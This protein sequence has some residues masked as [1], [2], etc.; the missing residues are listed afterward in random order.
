MK[1]KKVEKICSICYE[2][3]NRLCVKNPP[4]CIKCYGKRYSPPKQVCIKCGGLN[5]VHHYNNG[6]P[7]C[8]KCGCKEYVRKEECCQ[9]CLENKEIH[10]RQDGKPVCEACYSKNCRP[11]RTCVKC[12]N[13]GQTNGLSADGEGFV[14]KTC[15]KCPQILCSICGEIGQAHSSDDNDSPICKKCYKTPLEECFICGEE[16]HVHQRNDGNPICLNCYIPPSCECSV[17]HRLL[18]VH[19]R[20]DNLVL[21]VTC[22]KNIKLHNDEKFHTISLLRSRLYQAFISYSLKGKT[23][24]SKEYGIDYQAIFEYLGPCPGERKDWH[25]DHIIPLCRFDFDDLEQIKLAFASNNHQWLSAK[26]NMRKGS[27]LQGESECLF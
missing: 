18:P 6:N 14:C 15:Y 13:I 16:K 24:K 23:K 10:F 21:C 4:T 12:G 25:I 9:F 11:I 26:D 3:T 17:C 5:K 19:K 27:K 22:Y 1:C 7:V 20:E 2:T 8:H